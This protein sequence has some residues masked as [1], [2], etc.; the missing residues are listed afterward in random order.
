MP[1]VTDGGNP[2]GDAPPDQ[3]SE[4]IEWAR[5]RRSWQPVKTFTQPVRFTNPVP[6]LARTYVYCTV[7]K[8]PSSPFAKLALQLRD[9]PAWT[10][11]QLETGHNLHYTAPDDT[12]AILAGIGDAQDRGA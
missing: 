1:N 10:Y 9:D 7:G 6:N 8:D 3:P 2:P 12:V 5:P 4:I 11:H